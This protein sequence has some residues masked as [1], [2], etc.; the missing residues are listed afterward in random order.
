MA[1]SGNFVPFHTVDREWDAR[2]NVPTEEDLDCLLSSIKSEAQS[3]KF[4]YALVGGVE[5]GTRP[6]QD[7][8]LIRHVHCAFVYNNR[9]SK[10]SILKNLTI[11]QGNGYY[12]VPR[13]RDFPYSG[14]KA[15]HTKTDTKL[16][17]E[18]LLLYE[19]GTLPVDK[20]S[21][22]HQVTK[23][24]DEEKKRKLDDIIVEMR[25]LIENGKDDEA[26]TKFPRNYLTYGEK[27]KAMIMQK[28]D[29]F[30]TEGNPHIW[31]WGN[32][33]TG[34]SAILQVIYPDYYN[35]NL[36]NRF[37]DRYL[38]GKHSHVL[39]QDVDH[40]VVENLGVQ[41]FKSICDE[42]GYPIDAKYKTPQIARLTVLVSSNFPLEQ[43]V[44]EDLKGRRENLTALQR[45][46]WIVNI[47]HFLPLLGLKM[48]SKYEINQLKKQ[49]NL[50]PRKLFMAWDYLRD[51]PTGEPLKEAAEYQ[52]IIR[53]KFYG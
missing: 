47:V 50:D 10:S 30:K 24:S 1:T 42:A 34:K 21:P 22:E 18:S 8:Y 35:K 32:P 9:V 26:F 2:F 31:L 15:H 48:L 12:L 33:G 20:V 44:P 7:D 39:L 27:I 16:S 4:K 46:F 40:N 52:K 13:K 3:G 23:R 14:W 38:D 43:V 25:G 17:Q 19:Y 37:F 41:F 29:F 51:C 11:K 5:I 53:E 45:R 36:D 28:R 49:G 6:Y